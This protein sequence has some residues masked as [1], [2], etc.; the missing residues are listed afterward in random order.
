MESESQHVILADRLVLGVGWLH[1]LAAARLGR[2]KW[3]TITRK[4]AP[5]AAGNEEE[6]VGVTETFEMAVADYF[7]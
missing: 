1:S 2:E 5:R 7:L 4:T 3:A 6:T